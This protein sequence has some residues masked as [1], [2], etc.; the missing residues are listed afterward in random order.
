MGVLERR[1]CPARRWST[2]KRHDSSSRALPQRR[3]SRSRRL[4][5]ISRMRRNRSRG[6]A[7]SARAW[8]NGALGELGL[9]SDRPNI[10][11]NGQEEGRKD[12]LPTA[13]KAAEVE[14]FLSQVK[15]M[16]AVR[17]ASGRG[18][19]IFALDATASREDLGPGMPAAR[20]D[21]RGDGGDRRT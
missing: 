15:A 14:A 16:Q 9:S 12:Q 19:L 18:R 13:R 6:A 2:G 5:I 3:A 11:S 20:R 7:T 4:S 21:V 8:S 17:P 1:R 10:Q